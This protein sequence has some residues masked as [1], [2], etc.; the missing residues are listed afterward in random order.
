MKHFFISVFLIIS[1]LITFSQSPKEEIRAAWIATNY[2]LDWPSKPYSNSN[3]INDQQDEI[4]D[5][6]D[7]LS[8]ANFNM[9]FIQTRLRGDV[10]Y[11]SKIEPVSPYI[12]SVENNWSKYDPLAFTIAECHKRGLEC[13]AW[14]VTYPMGPEKVKGEENESPALKRNK[15]KTK[16]H[17]GEFYLDPGNPKT[18]DYLVS[19]IEEIVKNYN[20]DGIHFDYVRYPDK[21]SDFP[22]DN[23]FKRNKR[24]I[25]TKGE[26]RKDNINRFIY[27]VYEVIKYWKPWV[28]VSSSVIGFYDNLPNEKR[29]H[30]TA[31]GVSQDPENWLAAGKHD[32][33][34]PMM[35]YPDDLFFPFVSDWKKRSHDRHVVSGL[36][37]FKIDAKSDN[38]STE[39]IKKQIRFS[40][41][42]GLNGNAWFRSK[43][44]INNTKNIL[45]EL[46]NDLY[47]HPALL[48]PLT[49]LDSIPP[50]PPLEMEASISG[51]FLYL[52]WSP[53]LQW[54][55]E[56]VYYNVYRSETWPIDTS[57]AENLVIARVPTRMVF[58]PLNTKETGYYYAVTAYDRYHNESEL[59]DAVYFVTGP[60]EK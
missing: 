28:Q 11:N 46:K 35:Y 17:K 29:K 34:V 4:I 51:I 18:N 16:R 9:V 21:S 6:I 37:L 52:N 32:F 23:T 53:V 19:L 49:W 44:L 25:K 12:R 36:G 10:I 26:W 24:G 22:D 1:S 45:T 47:Q 14:F 13:H 20:I 43:Y 15:D 40:R 39:T 2:G 41:K 54:E 7:Q 57:K 58:L 33:I 48:P 3:E 31:L 42:Q 5:M 8:R 55:N 50:F 27:E 56:A 59:S 30:W 38:W 60:Y